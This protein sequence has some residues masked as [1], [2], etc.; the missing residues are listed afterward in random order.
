MV[1][2]PAPLG[3]MMAAHFAG[4][5]RKREVVERPKAVELTP[6]MPSR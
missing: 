6:V 1:V 5:D 3:P 2:L 4:L